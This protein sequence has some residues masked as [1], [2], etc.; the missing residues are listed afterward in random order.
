[1][2]LDNLGWNSFF[3]QNFNKYLSQGY[4]VG[5][6]VQQQKNTY[7][8]YSELGE[9]SAEISGK[10]RYRASLRADFPAVGDWVVIGDLNSQQKA[11][12][13]DILPRKSKVSR[14][15][16]G[17]Q[18][19]EQ[20][21]ASNIDTIFLVSGLDRDF[22][23]RR[24][25]RFLILI[26][27]SGANPV[28]ILNKADLCDDAEECKEEL[29]SIAFGVPIILISAI[30]NQGIDA[31]VPYLGVGK[32][33]ALIGSS[34]VGK[35][36]IT[37]QLAQKEIQAVNS[38]RKD[39]RGRHTTTHREL[40]ILP[41]GGL[42]I[43]TPGMREIQFWNGSEGFQETFT[44][45]SELASL[46]RFRDCQHDTEPGCAVQQALLDGTLDEERF[47]SYLKLQQEL[48]YM[49][50]KQDKKAS[51]VEKE[52]WK[53]IHKAIRKNPKRA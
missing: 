13:Y 43:D 34:G 42:L 23:P 30:G 48:A 21:I 19:D 4:T 38:L 7:I 40:I 10:M 49:T 33:V 27:E 1:M 2:N 45:I 52:K 46:C 8:L 35:S 17:T 6:V 26:W 9:I 3:A 51:L 36:T 28:I 5:R 12:I 53:K 41:S 44:E 37:N 18:T 14:K 39:E 31:L 22:N 32:T 15:I 29:E 47:D 11:T 20:I 16:A 24:I 50:R 25:E